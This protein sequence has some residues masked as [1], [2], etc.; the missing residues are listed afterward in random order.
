MP[1]KGLRAHTQ[2]NQG[3]GFSST[4][5]RRSL[6]RWTIPPA[7][8]RGWHLQPPLG[9]PF[10]PPRCSSTSQELAAKL[11][12][13]QTNLAPGYSPI[14]TFCS[15]TCPLPSSPTDPF[16]V[17]HTFLPSWLSFPQKGRGFSKDSNASQISYTS[18]SPSLPST[19]PLSLT[20]SPPSFQT[21]LRAASFPKPL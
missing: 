6:R 3:P 14:F 2:G 5:V 4:L 17:L 9:P 16:A 8:G 15:W 11:S 10:W 13:T 1:W 21:Q 12:S 19:T 18:P 20:R 7:G